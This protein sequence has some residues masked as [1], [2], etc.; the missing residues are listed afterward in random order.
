[1]H[2][3]ALFGSTMYSLHKYYKKYIFL[4]LFIQFIFSLDLNDRL[5]L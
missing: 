5:I 2:R 3:M 1:M 4:K